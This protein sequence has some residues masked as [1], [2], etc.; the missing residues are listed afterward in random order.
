[1]A[2]WEDIKPVDTEKGTSGHLGGTWCDIFAKKIS[3]ISDCVL[4]F[5]RNRTKIK[6]S[7]KTTGPFWHGEAHCKFAN[8]RTF[9]MTILNDP[10][11][12]NDNIIVEINVSGRENHKTAMSH[13]RHTRKTERERIRKELGEFTPTH[14]HT[15]K[16]ASANKEKLLSGNLDQVPSIPV[17]QKISSEK[18][19]QDRYNQNPFLDISLVQ[20]A[21]DS[22]S[23]GTAL[24]HHYVQFIGMSPLTVH[25]YSMPQL[26]AMKKKI[27][28]RQLCL[29]LDATGTVVAKPPNAKNVLYYALCMPLE[30]PKPTVVPLAEMITSDQTSVNIQNWLNC[31]SRDYTSIYKKEFTPTKVETDFSWAI[32][33]ATLASLSKCT[34]HQY[35][36]RCMEVCQETEPCTFTIVHICAA[37]MIKIV[38]DKAS[39][40]KCSKS[41]RTLFLHAFAMVQNAINLKEIQMLLHMILN[42]FSLHTMTSACSSINELQQAI[43][44]QGFN[45]EVKAALDTAGVDQER[46]KD[47]GKTQKGIV[48][49][50]PFTRLFNEVLTMQEDNKGEMDRG[51][52]TN[53]HFCPDLVNIFK[54]YIGTLP[55]WSGIMLGHL[56]QTR[57]T[58]AYAENWFRTTKT[59]VLRDKLH[60]RPGQFIQ[61][62]EEFVLGRL[63]GSE[64]HSARQAYVGNDEVMDDPTDQPLTQKETW[65]KKGKKLKASITIL[66]KCKKNGEDKYLPTLVW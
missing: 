15:K 66:Q 19:L 16:M 12:H 4:I 18:N 49:N 64:I 44:K 20:Q 38:A 42:V 54:P 2:E 10:G 17:L 58:N 50:S 52:P 28:N 51:M 7:R 61:I 46:G 65:Q 29:Y 60:R 43:Q 53:P 23:E 1:Q 36:Q 21:Q 5:K 35:L 6:D 32:I 39:K 13:R 37:H 30:F 9:Q 3:T 33:H 41:T 57:D 56:G 62:M 24:R 48:R 8:C 40:V 22:R 63:K 47:E 34:I 27:D 11:I 25:M 59:V 55:L 14:I 45:N 31:L 26:Q